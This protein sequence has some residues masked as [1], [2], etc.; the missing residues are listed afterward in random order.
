L[1][2]GDQRLAGE[3]AL[4]AAELFGGNDDHFV[5]AVHGQCCGPSLRTRRT[6]SLERAV[7]SC[8]SQRPDFRSR[9]RRGFGGLDED[10][11][12]LVMLTRLSWPV[13]LC[14][15]VEFRQMCMIIKSVFDLAAR[16]AGLPD[17]ALRPGRAGK[18][19]TNWAK[20]PVV[21]SVYGNCMG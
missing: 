15:F 17:E 8:N 4:E 6:S 9:V 5:A 3:I 16:G 12:I 21:L 18:S 10:F 7:A 20:P 11:T 14:K 19:K 13:P 1:H 2:R